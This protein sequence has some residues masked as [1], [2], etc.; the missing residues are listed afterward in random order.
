MT[1]SL[2]SLTI[3]LL[4]L[5]GPRQGPAAPQA[6]PLRPELIGLLDFE[7]DHTG[8]VPKG[9]GGHPP[10]TF[11]VDDQVVH[12]GRWSLRIERKADGPDGFTAV[13]RML[14]IDF[15]GGRL[16]LSGFLRTENVAGFA[17]LWMR[18][19]GDSGAVAFDNMES[20]RLNGTTG[21]TEYTIALPLAPG[22]KRLFFGV[23]A[24]G[25]GRVW[26]DDLRLLVD[27]KPVA[28]APR[29]EPER[30]ALD[31]DK[32]FDAGSGITLKDLTKTQT[33]NLAMLGKVWGFLKYHHPAIVAGKRHWDYDLLRVLPRVLS[34]PDVP[35]ARAVV[36]A[37]VTGLGAVPACRPC[38]SLADGELH[39]KPPVTWLT[40]DALGA[41]LAGS[42]RDIH[43]NRPAGE[44]QFY[45]SLMPNVGNPVFNNEPTYAALKLPDA[46][47]QLLGL[48]R[49]WNIIEYWFPYRD[50]IGENWDDVL[51]TFIPRTALAADSDTYKREMMAL[52]ARVH[53]THA[54]LFSSLDV[55]PPVGACRIPVITRFIQDKAVVTESSQ[56]G[57]GTAAG[58]QIGDVIDAIDGVAVPALLERWAPYYAASN[59]PARL[60]DIAQSMTRGACGAVTVRVTRSGGAVDVNTQR[61]SES[62]PPRGG[63]RTHDRPGETFQ[64]LSPDVAYLKLSSV[65][66]AQAAKYIESAAGTKGLIVD[67]RNYP[68]EFMVFALGSRLVDRPTPFAR[69]T[70]GDPANPGA[71]HWTPPL[72]LE[73][74][75]PRYAGKIVILVDELSLSQSEY[76]AMALRAAPNATVV[77]STTAGADGN[78][79][80]VP[81]PGGLGS[82]ISGIGVFY[83]DK[84]P[85]QR[86]GILP[87]IEARPTI[88]GIRNGRD[89]VVEAALRHILGPGA[90]ASEIERMARR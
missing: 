40:D 68:S 87:D 47:Y 67:I 9:W 59:Q 5:L 33:A 29:I 21:W 81:L 6:A 65:Q 30:T 3:M 42:L 58:L 18:Q 61:T 26:A 49:F 13:T 73:P 24:S 53:D 20:R 88:E 46:G 80:R 74:A 17:G 34:A 8:G 66:A 43:R 7:S 63:R 16:E 37:W 54:N 38:A 31:L 41:A 39:L 76:T 55:R 10:G 25:A 19:D 70:R 27:G 48:Y 71:F 45:V 64:K 51:T 44:R 28:N 83:P 82:A 32:E 86:I 36:L 11:A 72:S 50:V 56:A 79:S 84:K 85:T 14:P 1:G 35:A 78:V 57:P 23:L 69:F 75:L 2:A 52:I 22:A 4:V 15:A 77:G 89:E 12:G 90:A 60:R 62:G